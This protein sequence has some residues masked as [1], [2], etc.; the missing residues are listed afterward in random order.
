MV[1]EPAHAHT[2]SDTHAGAHPLTQNGSFSCVY[3]LEVLNKFFISLYS[4]IIDMYYQ[5]ISATEILYVLCILFSCSI[6]ISNMY[7][8]YCYLVI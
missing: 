2:D 3:R 4:Y 5:Q 1:H 6:V 8:V 7:F